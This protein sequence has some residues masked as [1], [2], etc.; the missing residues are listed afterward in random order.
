MDLIYLYYIYLHNPFFSILFIKGDR[1][2][3]SQTGL[4]YSTWICPEKFSDPHSDPHAIRLLTLVRNIQGRDEQ[5]MCLSI[6]V[7]SRDKALL[8]STTET[9]MHQSGMTLLLCLCIYVYLF[10]FLFYC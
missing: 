9:L 7:S 6:Q 3:P 10:S 1:V 5:L 2:F 8:I 4:S